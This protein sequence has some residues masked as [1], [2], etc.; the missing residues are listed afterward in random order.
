MS[1]KEQHA[2]A[3][4]T[5]D[6]GAIRDN[7]RLLCKRTGVPCA[8]AVKADAYGLGVVQVAPLLV[9]EGCRHFFVAHIDEG[10]ALRALVPEH[11][12]IYVLHGQPLGTDE[13]FVEWRL[14]PVLNSL[15]QIEDWRKTAERLNRVL[16]AVIHFDTGM[17]RLG[18]ERSEVDIL[19]ADLQLLRGIDVRYLMSHLA[20][21]ERHD[22][23]TNE[24]Q[25][26][27]FKAILERFPKWPA[28]LANSGGIFNRSDFY[29]DMVRSGAALCGIS[30]IADASVPNPMRVVVKLQ[31]KIIQTRTIE[32][33]TGVGYSQT[34]RAPGRRR[35]AT[36]SLGYADGLLRHFSNRG[37]AYVG[38][39][40][41]PFV[42]I[43]SMDAI[44]LDVSDVDP[45]NLYPGAL[46]DIFSERQTV[47][48]M[49]DMAGTVAYELLTKM[50][51]RYYRKYVD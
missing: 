27:A 13:E 46:I 16:P 6:L 24:M 43:V 29:F 4:M 17:S 37:V 8:G 20:C 40:A 34:Y 18:M 9:E 38:D 48:K 22:N 42:G 23:P 35:L 12:E 49:A 26:Q 11:V 39:V 50:G 21:G 32:Q 30:P 33:G 41:V 19:A 7:Y 45:A 10:I 44:T 14:T 15:Q 36:I 2:G 1:Q 28:T 5:I 3:I 25:L 31:A 51:Y 47:D